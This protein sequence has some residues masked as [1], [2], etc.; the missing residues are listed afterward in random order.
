MLVAELGGYLG[1]TLGVSLL[2]ME[3]LMQK[4]ARFC[5]SEGDKG[6]RYQGSEED[7]GNS[8]GSNRYRGKVFVA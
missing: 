4:I 2:D 1:M 3:Q 7:K 5:R 8:A 6:N